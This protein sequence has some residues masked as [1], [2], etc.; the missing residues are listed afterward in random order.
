MILLETLICYKVDLQELL[1]CGGISI[2]AIIEKKGE[3]SEKFLH[4][5]CFDDGLK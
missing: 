5:I 4:R 1:L 2:F 3:K